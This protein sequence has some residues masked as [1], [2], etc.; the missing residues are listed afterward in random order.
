[1]LP[2][3]EFR[4]LIPPGCFSWR[5][6]RQAQL[7]RDPGV[8]PELAGGIIYPIWPGNTSG[9]CRR[10]CGTTC[11]TCW[12]YNP[13][14]DKWNQMDGWVDGCMVGYFIVTLHMAIPRAREFK[15]LFCFKWC[16]IYFPEEV[17]LWYSGAECFL[18]IG[19]NYL[20]VYGLNKNTKAAV[21]VNMQSWTNYIRGKKLWF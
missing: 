4:Y 11:L 16:V 7:G 13:T 17:T 1:M 10:R 18:C 20:L 3:T 12:H 19:G 6:S 15:S 14:L 2:Y 5:F 8:D 9:S 21:T